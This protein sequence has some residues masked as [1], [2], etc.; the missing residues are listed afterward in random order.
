M[1]APCRHFGTCGGCALQDL[2]A[3]TYRARKRDLIA[4]ALA[5]VGIEAAVDDLFVTPPGSRRRVEFQIASDGRR[6][7]VGFNARGTH[8][9]VDIAMCPVARPELVALAFALRDFAPRLGRWR[10]DA[11][12]TLTPTGI[13][14][15]FKTDKALDRTLL[16]RFAIAQHL[17]RI[18]LE[19]DIVLSPS[20]PVA[21]FDGI[22]V[23]L[24]PGAFLQATTEGE[25]AIRAEIEAATAKSK[26]IVDLYAGCGTFSLPLARRATVWALEGD[27]AMVQAMDRAA[28]AAGIGPRL[29]AERRDLK[30]RPVRPEELARIE[31]VIFDPPFEGAAAQA[32]ELARAKL[33]V[34]VGV[35]CNPVSFARDARTLIDGGHRL[36]RIV[37]IDQFLWSAHVE[38]VGVFRR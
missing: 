19:H 14:L 20:R 3:E 35:S 7:Q 15:V 16:T 36:T 31:A 6:A 10:G 18:T 37:A 2:D 29:K 38:L 33:P 17:A 34:I 24:P 8:D 25:A 21:R 32:A 9:I 11:R 22:E 23:D 27:D 12:A 4:M 30:R 1:T 5:R 26:R 28:R 13:D